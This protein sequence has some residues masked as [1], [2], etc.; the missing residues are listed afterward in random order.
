MIAAA[1]RCRDRR[2]QHLRGAARGL[3]A[4]P[5]QLLVDRRL[6]PPEPRRRG[7]ASGC[8]S[9]SRRSSAAF[10]WDVVTLKYGTLLESRLRRAG[11]RGAAG[12]DRRLPQPALCRPELPGRGG[13][14]PRLIDDDRRPGRPRSGAHRAPLATMRAL[15]RL[16]TNLGGHDMPSLLDA[17]DGAAEHDRPTCFIAYTIKGFGLPL[18]GPQGQPLGPD[19]AGPDG[20]L[21]N[22][23]GHRQ[24]EEWDKFD[25]LGAAAPKTMRALPRRACR[26]SPKGTP[27]PRGRQVAVPDAA[28]FPP[29]PPACRRRQGFGQHPQRPRAT[30]RRARRRASSPPRRT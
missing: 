24:G 11:R 9:A 26:S 13:L 3:E 6:Q 28:A 4:R 5:P 29:Q 21:R 14:A 27:A 30:E 18:A 17:F 20:G 10:G 15:P 23:D 1:G 12:L 19:D 25:G 2:G 22:G 7:R 16:M 8:A